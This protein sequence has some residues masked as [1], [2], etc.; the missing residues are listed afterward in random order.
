[1]L[2]LNDVTS[3]LTFQTLDRTRLEAVK[4]AERSRLLHQETMMR[5]ADHPE[6]RFLFD[7]YDTLKRPEILG[8]KLIVNSLTFTFNPFH[9]PTPED[10]LRSFLHIYHGRSDLLLIP[11]LKVMGYDDHGRPEVQ[12][13]EEEFRRYVDMAHEILNYRNSKPIFIPIPFK[14]GGRRFQSILDEYLSKG[15]RY[16]WLDF[17]GSN[18]TSKASY[19]RAFHDKVDSEG[20]G[21]EVI[22]YGSNIRARKQSSPSRSKM[23]CHRFPYCAAG[24]RYYWCEP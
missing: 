12:V 19:I 8:D 9:V 7:S 23:S 1:M 3:A 17:G 6:A 24:S 21:E 18:T 10:Y 13:Q 11:N 16:F 22:L 4:I 5:E 20:L 2:D 14:Y 15:Y